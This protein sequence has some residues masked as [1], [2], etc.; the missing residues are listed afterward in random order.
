MLATLR[1]KIKT[2]KK[3]I[4]NEEAAVSPN[5]TV[6]SK[7]GQKNKLKFFVS[8]LHCDQ[9]QCFQLSNGRLR[10]CRLEKTSQQCNREVPSC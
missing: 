9:K 5:G 8:K 7:I 1:K 6:V 4:L 3:Q 2:N 10:Y